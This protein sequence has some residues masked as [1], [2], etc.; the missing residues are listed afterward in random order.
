MARLTIRLMGTFEVALDGKRVSG[1]VSDKARALLAYLA[2]EADQPHRREAL[3]GLLW[4]DYPERAARA[5]L[6]NVLANLRQEIGD[7]D[8]HPPFLRISPQAIQLNPEGDAWVDV[9]SFEQLLGGQGGASRLHLLEESI[10]LY[11]GDFLEGFSLPGS[12]AFEEW[13]LLEREQLQRRALGALREL[14]EHYEGRGD[15]GRALSYAWRQVEIE[16]YPEGAQRQLLRLLAR[17]GQRER[18]LVQYKGYSELLAEELGVAPGE[19][20]KQL[21][22]AICDDEDLSPWAPSPPAGLELPPLQTHNLPAQST[23]FVGRERELADVS[24]LLADPDV[25][26][27][28]VVGPGGMGKTRLALEM[29]RQSLPHF[30]AGGWW[31]DLAPLPEDASVPR[32]VAA[33]LGVLEQPDRPLHE[34]I[35]DSLQ[36]RELLLV[37]DNCEHVVEGAAGLVSLLLS[38]CPELAVLATSREPLHASGEHLY[39]TPPMGLPEAGEAVERLLAADAVQLFRQRAAAVRSD[40]RLEGCATLVTKVCR[41]LDGMPLAIELA[42]A[43]LRALSLAEVA[44]RLDD[45]FRLLTGGSRTAHPRQRTLRNTIAWSVDLLEHAEP[46]LFARLSAFAGSFDLEGTEEVC[47]GAGVPAVEVLDLLSRLVDKSLVTLVRAEGGTTRYRLLETVRAYA[48]ERLAARGEADEIAAKHA[49]CYLAL[50]E[51]LEPRLVA[52]E[53][54]MLSVFARLDAEADNLAA[55]MRWSLSSRQPEVALRIG[56]ALRYWLEMRDQH[57]HPYAEWL[58]RALAHDDRGDP[59]C[60]ARAL[61]PI[62]RS[63]QWQG[64]RDKQTSAAEEALK[65]ARKTGDPKLIGRAAWDMGVMVYTDQ[66]EA[67]RSLFQETLQAGREHGE[68]VLVCRAWEGLAELE[69]D[70]AKRCALLEALLAQV[71]YCLQLFPLLHLGDATYQLGDLARAEAWRRRG[72]ERAIELGALHWQASQLHQL[73]WIARRRGDYGQALALLARSQALLL[74][75]GVTHELAY[76]VWSMGATAWYRGDL[77]QASQH[78]EQSLDLSR[79]HGFSDAA[80]DAQSVLALVACEQGDYNRA[81]ALCVAAL[82]DLP[83]GYVYGQ[84]LATSGLARVALCR[85]DAPRAIDLYREAMGHERRQGPPHIID[86]LEPLC[87]A[88]AADGQA[89]EA[90][91]LL[92]CAARER[93]EMG[94]TLHPV[95]RPYHDRAVEA[96]RAALDEKAFA[97]AWAKGE[98]LDLDEA[99]EQALRD[100]NGTEPGTER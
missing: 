55:A 44:A 49:R 97:A 45:R 15:P 64:N 2:V 86:A 88:L 60:R 43:R 65:L 35:A 75:I 33:A 90:V 78:L 96:V 20:T 36:T 69:R 41:R 3:A 31:V 47:G 87:W 12:P 32:A 27:V 74:R 34:V 50:A 7:R 48:R 42:A 99:I 95:D 26:L 25:R 85:G 82:G 73:G 9:V 23:P 38:R 68:P 52:Q 37:L 100:Q 1:F 14:A 22:Q 94:M 8:A 67:G 58:E 21:L 81:E 19:E 51:G 70:P 18:A 80:A 77:A 28:T 66:P 5:S 29:A 54:E 59:V 98:G 56:G 6:R 93:A 89:E 91:R 39:E 84:C 16:P 92:A 11:R 40:F 83:E 57:L 46:L 62:W 71:P 13:A 10:A 61:G 17:D 53:K 72:L 79:Q 24:D 4:G 76:V 30:P 63:A